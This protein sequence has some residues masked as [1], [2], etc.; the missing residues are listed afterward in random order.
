MQ[1]SPNGD[2]VLIRMVFAPKDIKMDPSFKPK[3]D[4]NVEKTSVT[5]Q[6]NQFHEAICSTIICWYWIRPETQSRNA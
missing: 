5:K 6:N 3:V 4:A 1:S 2:K